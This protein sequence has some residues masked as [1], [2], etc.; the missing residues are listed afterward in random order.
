MLKVL[1]VRL[2]LAWVGSDMLILYL[3]VLA[4]IWSCVH[5]LY[6]GVFA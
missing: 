1:A 6:L 3:D 4:C 2:A 5:I